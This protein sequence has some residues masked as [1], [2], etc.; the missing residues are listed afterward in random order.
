M[1]L[2]QHFLKVLAVAALLVGCSANKSGNTIES[3][4]ANSIIGG[5]EVAE[6]APLQKSIVA[7]YDIKRGSLCTGSLLE[8]NIVLTAAHCVGEAPQDHVVIFT[9]NLENLRDK[10]LRQAKLRVVTKT[11]VHPDWGNGPGSMF[12]PM[13]DTAVIKFQGDIPEGF[14]PAK[15]LAPDVLKEG[16]KVVVA[17]Y[18]VSEN[19]VSEVNPTEHADFEEKVKSGEFACMT[20]EDGTK[21]KCF[22]QKSSGSGLL[23]TT[24]LTIVGAPNE[25]EVVME[26]SNGQAVCMG[27]S[28]GPA[29]LQVNGELYLFGVASRVSY[30]CNYLAVHSDITTPKLAAWLATA[31][32]EVSQTTIAEVSQ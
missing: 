7:I 4:K 15:L 12:N 2:Q 32:A 25:T 6:G 16:D 24:E 20:A 18:G 8:N 22:T 1:N 13:S 26:Q 19:V 5:T 23:R 30:G 14:A 3:D 21:S 9:N 27:D 10:N 29:Y 17:G 11:S 31:I 28:G